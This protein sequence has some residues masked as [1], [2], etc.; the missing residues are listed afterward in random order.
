MELQNFLFK[1]NSRSMQKNYTLQ[2]DTLHN[3]DLYVT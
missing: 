2:V 1:F 3:V